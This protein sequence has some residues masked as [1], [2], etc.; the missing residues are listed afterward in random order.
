MVMVVRMVGGANLWVVK[1]K[2]RVLLSKQVWRGGGALG[3]TPKMT[4]APT[5]SDERTGS[6]LLNSPPCSARS[7]SARFFFLASSRWGCFWGLVDVTRLFL[8][9]SGDGFCLTAIFPRG[10]LPREDVTLIKGGSEI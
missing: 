3:E 10:V 5:R 6:G 8:G 7:S 1:G 4:A 2:G 9:L